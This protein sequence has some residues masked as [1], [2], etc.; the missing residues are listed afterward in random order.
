VI[1][2]RTLPN[3]FARAARRPG[4]KGAISKIGSLPLDPH[5]WYYK[6]EH[7]VRP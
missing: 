1:S 2:V 3:R 6:T 5:F 4:R 7:K